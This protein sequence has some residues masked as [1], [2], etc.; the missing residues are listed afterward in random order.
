VVFESSID[1]SRLASHLLLP[2]FVPEG[3]S[4][5]TPK[6]NTLVELLLEFKVCLI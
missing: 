4:L 5:V 3:Q 1:R 2:Q 6:A